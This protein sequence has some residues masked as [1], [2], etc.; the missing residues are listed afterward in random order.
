MKEEKGQCRENKMADEL[1]LKSN[2]RYL[3]E[4]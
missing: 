3:N 1:E 2:V 4:R